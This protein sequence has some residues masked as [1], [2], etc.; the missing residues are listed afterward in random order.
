MKIE[1]KHADSICLA[2]VARATCPPRSAARR[3]EWD[4]RSRSGNALS[5]PK[6]L[7]FRRATRPTKR[8]KAFFRREP[9]VVR[10]GSAI[11]LGGSP[12]GTGRLPVPPILAIHEVM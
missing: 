2:W 1:H 10:D 4:R 8:E 11:P 3:A 9:L 6:R 7:P 5:Y 12:T